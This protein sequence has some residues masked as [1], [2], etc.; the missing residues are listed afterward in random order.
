[1]F[2]NKLLF[3]AESAPMV[4]ESAWPI[5]DDIPGFKDQD[6]LLTNPSLLMALKPDISPRPEMKA[7]PEEILD[8]MFE[9][10]ESPRSQWRHTTDLV[11]IPDR[12][13]T[14]QDS[15]TNKRAKRKPKRKN[16]AT[17]LLKQH[18]DV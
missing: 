7:E 2:G 12:T 4:A 10:M 15:F 13:Y 17:E 8:E 16:S 3:S 6:T 14:T 9:I 1:M 5:L 18:I 11:C